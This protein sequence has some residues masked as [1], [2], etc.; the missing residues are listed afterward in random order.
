MRKTPRS[1][2]DDDDDDFYDLR[3]VEVPPPLTT[4]LHLP[5]LLFAAQACVASNPV[6]LGWDRVRFV[7]RARADLSF[8]LR[9]DVLGMVWHGPSYTA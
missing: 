8:C 9:S 4:A 6:S 7:G 2:N 1:V 5:L 3:R